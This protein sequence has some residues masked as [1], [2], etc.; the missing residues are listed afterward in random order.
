[1]NFTGKINLLRFKSACVIDV[2]GKTMK[3]RGVFIPIDDNCLF[4]SAD[5]KGNAKGVY[6]DFMAWEN[7]QMSQFG[8]THSIKQNY[9]KEVRQLM[10]EEDM[11]TIPYFGNLKPY[12]PKNRCRRSRRSGK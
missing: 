6:V 11:K 1:M 9:P 8:D 4:V 7:R 5:D 10:C 12:E 2:Q 3:K